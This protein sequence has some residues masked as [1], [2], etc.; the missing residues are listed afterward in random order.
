MNKEINIF[1]FL[2]NFATFFSK[3]SKGTAA[4]SRNN[5]L[6]FVQ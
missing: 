6:K 5:E 2:V 1:L 4:Y 3:M